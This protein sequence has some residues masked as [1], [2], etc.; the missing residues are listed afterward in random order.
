M[1]ASS[2]SAEV[3][4]MTPQMAQSILDSQ[5][6]SAHQRKLNRRL[7]S[8]Y[9][10]EMK[11]GA[12]ALNGESI[13]FNGSKLL[14]GQHRLSAVVASGVPVS[15]LVVRGV[16]EAAFSTIDQGRV[17]NINDLLAIRGLNY[18]ASFGAAARLAMVYEQYGTAMPT[19]EQRPTRRQVMEYIE[20]HAEA[21]YDAATLAAGCKIGHQPMLTA[22]AFLGRGRTERPA[23][24]EKLQTGVGLGESEPVRLLRDRLLVPSTGNARPHNDYTFAVAIKAWN[25]TVLQK[26]LALLRFRKDEEYPSMIR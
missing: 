17:R 14:N 20:R 26:P 25:A 21:L 15:L 16:D 12:W 22:L 11:A 6:E 18:K 24:F 10:R 5:P 23:F 9:A 7:V 3:V 2:I 13:Q 1:N 4:T 19:M 8:S